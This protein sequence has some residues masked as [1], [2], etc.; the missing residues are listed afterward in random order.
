MNK[1]NILA[2]AAGAILGLASQ[3][4]LASIITYTAT[5]SGPAE[6]PPVASPGS[7]SAMLTYD[8]LLHTLLVD[9]SFSDLIGTVTNA[10]IHSCTAA[11]NIGNIG[12][13]TTLPTFPG[14]PAGVTAGVYNQLFDLTDPASFNAAFVTN[15]G[16][17]AASAELALIAGLDA[18]KAY[19][20]IHTTAFPGGEIRGFMAAV[21]E[22]SSLLLSGLGLGLVAWQYRRASRSGAAAQGQSQRA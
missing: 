11:A 20:N 18:G 10:H 2:L 21:P 15:N 8:S 5:L 9:A 22:P 14:F 12:V 3:S 17:T 7:G 16:G 19:F 13:A 4:S 6:S 1:K